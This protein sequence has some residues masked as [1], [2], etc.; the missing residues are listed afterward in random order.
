MRGA[1]VLRHTAHSMCSVKFY[2]EVDQWPPNSY[3]HC[4]KKQEKWLGRHLHKEMLQ[5][6]LLDVSKWCHLN[7]FCPHLLL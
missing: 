2:K 4:T 3:M 7:I 5:A 6:C 1:V